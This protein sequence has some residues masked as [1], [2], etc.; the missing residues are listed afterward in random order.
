MIFENP[1][2]VSGTDFCPKRRGH[3]LR[4]LER[5]EQCFCFRIFWRIH[6]A[7][8]TENELNKKLWLACLA[9][10]GF[11][12]RC[13]TKHWRLSHPR[14]SIL[15]SFL[16]ANYCLQ[17]FL[18]LC[19]FIRVSQTAEASATESHAAAAATACTASARDVFCAL[20]WSRKR[21]LFLDCTAIGRCFLVCSL[22]KGFRNNRL[23]LVASTQFLFTTGGHAHQ[24]NKDGKRRR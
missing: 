1:L 9:A 24:R 11:L 10:A 16:F 17:C 15:V 18:P 12:M 19:R 3:G 21:I 5:G 13:R 20:M 7:K 22:E 23:F 6:I 2:E 8:G 14:R 4:A